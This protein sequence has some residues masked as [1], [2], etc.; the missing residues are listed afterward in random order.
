MFSFPCYLQ[1]PMM[2]QQ[3]SGLTLGSQRLP[4]RTAA[5]QTPLLGK[6][7]PSLKQQLEKEM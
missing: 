6:S 3:S 1:C 5:P 7:V 2:E 4:P